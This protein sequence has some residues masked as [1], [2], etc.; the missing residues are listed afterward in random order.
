MKS[1][2]RELEWVRSALKARQSKSRHASAYEKLLEQ[3]K[4]NRNETNKISIP[5]GPRLGDIVIE[6]DKLKGFGDKLLIEDL[7]FRLPL[8]A[9]SGLSGQT[10][11]GNP[12]CLKC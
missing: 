4:E 6:A 8:V 12:P 2:S 3:D 9:L 11:Q 5:A 10:G 1:L 7:S